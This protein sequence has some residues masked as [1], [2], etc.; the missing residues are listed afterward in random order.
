MSDSHH[1]QQEDP[2][3]CFR[4]GLFFIAVLTVITLIGLTH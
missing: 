1:H 2:A 4:V 3:I